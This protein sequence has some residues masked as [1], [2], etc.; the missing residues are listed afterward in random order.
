MSSA[1]NSTPSKPNLALMG[2]LGF[3]G[4]A[5]LVLAGMT[6]LLLYQENVAFQPLP[7]IPTTGIILPSATLTESP[8]PTTTGTFTVTPTFAPTAT[9]TITPTFLPTWTLTFTRTPT[10]LATRTRTKTPVATATEAPTTVNDNSYS[11]TYSSWRGVSNNRALGKGMRCSGQKDETLIYFANQ[12]AAEIGVIFFRGPN[13]GMADVYV[14]NILRETVDLY[15][16]TPK[17]GY[18]RLYDG[19]DPNLTSHELKIVVRREKR[20]ESNGYQVC[21]D[22]FRVDGTRVDDTNYSVQYGGWMGIQNNRALGRFFRT[23]SSPGVT[24]TF[25]T[26]G[27]YFTW[28]TATGPSY[29]QADV[30]ADDRFLTNVDLYSAVYK[31]QAQILVRGAG[32]GRHTIKIVVLGQHNSASSGNDVVFDG[33]LLP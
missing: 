10:S 7:T 26:D 5:M 9:P 22:A 19:L 11:I 30:Y 2:C 8:T 25:A 33:L 21:V 12:S 1:K 20:A 27:P 28:I 24:L 3:V 32:P 15:N 4:F 6:A 13:Y 31:W 23:A 18:E 17:P 14:D 16:A 29:G